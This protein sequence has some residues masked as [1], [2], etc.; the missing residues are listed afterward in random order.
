MNPIN[1]ILFDLDGTLVQHSHVLLVPKL[2]EWGY[3]RSAQRIEAVFERQIEWL[4]EFAARLDDEQKR[5]DHLWF[6]IWRELY[7]RVT[8]DLEIA[9]PQVAEHMDSYFR[10]QPTPPLFGDVR[11]LLE[12]LAQEK[13]LLGVITQRDR[14]AA[15]RF[16]QENQVRD[17]FRVVVGG[18]DGHGRK[19]HAGPFHAALRQLGR[20]PEE[21]VYIGDQINDDCR[22]AVGAGLSRAFLIDRSG[23]QVAKA[24]PAQPVEFIHLN[25]LSDLLPHLPPAIQ[26]KVRQEGA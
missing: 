20:S 10:D 4:Y 12:Q 18:D 8:R 23:R 16:L 21:A 13:W 19:P 1:T 2:A 17:C 11:P 6:K 14:V 26:D 24:D 15:E 3:A 7:R 25:S 5:D 9:N 22:G